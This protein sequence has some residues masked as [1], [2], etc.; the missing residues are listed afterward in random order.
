MGGIVKDA[1]L[2]NPNHIVAVTDFS[3]ETIRDVIAHMRLSATFEQ[4]IFREAE[5]NA[6][7]SLSAFALQQHSSADQRDRIR[8]FREALVES[9]NLL[10]EKRPLVATEPLLLFAE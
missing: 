5:L 1:V 10:G 4:L 6:L 2:T 9:H 3:P 8:R 7:W